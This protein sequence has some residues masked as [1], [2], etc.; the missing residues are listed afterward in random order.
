MPCPATPNVASLICKYVNVWV[1]AKSLFGYSLHAPGVE[2]HN[3]MIC[4]HHHHNHHNHRS[5]SNLRY[6]YRRLV[7]CEVHLPVPPSSFPHLQEFVL[8]EVGREVVIVEAEEEITKIVSLLST[9]VLILN[10]HRH[11]II[12]IC[13]LYHHFIISLSSCVC[14][15]YTIATICMCGGISYCE[16]KSNLLH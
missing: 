8:N 15:K 3:R 9:I 7:F 4:H 6:C 2:P 16:T 12:L 11:K 14:V 13:I 1:E 10:H 5:H